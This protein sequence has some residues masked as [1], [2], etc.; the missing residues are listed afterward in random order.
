MYLRAG[1]PAPVLTPFRN[2]ARWF[3]PDGV[4]I[5]ENGLTPDIEVEITREDFEA[6]LDPQFEKALEVVR[7][8]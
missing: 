5:S 3:T 2:F 7:G 1:P 4:S 8:E 6:G